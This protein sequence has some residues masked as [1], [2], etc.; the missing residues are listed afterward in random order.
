MEDKKMKYNKA[1]N[2]LLTVNAALLALGCQT[3]NAGDIEQGK[4]KSIVCNHCHQDNDDTSIPKIS[5]Q[6]ED[7]LVKQ[8]LAY[9]DG[10]R[11]DEIMQTV[12]QRLKSELDIYDIAAYFSSLPKETNHNTADTA[13]N[14]KQ[15]PLGH[16][17][18]NEK[19]NCYQCHGE[20]GQGNPSAV[21]IVPAI[22]GQNKDYIVK[23]LMEFQQQQHTK[24]S[25]NPMPGIAQ[26]LDI[27]DIFSVAEYLSEID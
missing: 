7:Y 15:P 2:L 4:A 21:P 6:H 14:D 16:Q 11:E 25:Q 5:G 1:K 10:K 18:F 13:A 23:R 19:A 9:R 22:A 20:D 3:V 8:M 26:K 27:V 12:M 24:P 17:V